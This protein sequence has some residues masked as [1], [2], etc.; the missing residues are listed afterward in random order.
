[1]GPNWELRH[2]IAQGSF[3]KVYYG[4]HSVTKSPVAVKTE[5]LEVRHPQLVGEASIYM[6]INQCPR[7]SPTLYEKL[8]SYVAFKDDFHWIYI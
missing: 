2:K 8:S 6:A 5:P 7:L 1:M 3:G 4:E